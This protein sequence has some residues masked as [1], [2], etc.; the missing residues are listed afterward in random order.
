VSRHHP[1]VHIVSILD[2]WDRATEKTKAAVLRLEHDLAGGVHD[3]L[4]DETSLLHQGDVTN[5]PP[6]GESMGD[7]E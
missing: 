1:I 5:L 6:E 3:A 4:F 7:G 2:N